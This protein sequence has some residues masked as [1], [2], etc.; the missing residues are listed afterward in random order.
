MP[1]EEW[2]KLFCLTR[3]FKYNG[4][5]DEYKEIY[6]PFSV[7]LSPDGFDKAVEL[8]YGVHKEEYFKASFKNDGS[9]EEVRKRFLDTLEEILYKLTEDI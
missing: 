9:F 1:R 7:K 3:R 4:S 8:A 6:R 5:F 2:F